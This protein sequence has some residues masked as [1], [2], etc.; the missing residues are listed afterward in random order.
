MF[1]YQPPSVMYVSQYLYVLVENTGIIHI[2]HSH[3]PT[4]RYVV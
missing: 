2:W 4:A 1:T 3:P